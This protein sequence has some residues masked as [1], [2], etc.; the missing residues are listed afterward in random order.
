METEASR[1]G[2]TYHIAD[3]G[4][5][6]NKGEKTVTMYS[7]TGD[8]FR[9]R[10]QINSV[11]RPSTQSVGS[12]TNGNNVLFT[13]TGGWII[14]HETGRYTRFPREHGVHV[15]HSWVIESPTETHVRLPDEPFPGR[16]CQ[17]SAIPRDTWNQRSL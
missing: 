8:Q 10:C 9:A 3:E 7:E 11:T 1:Q 4:V 13:P 15:L 6:K 5:I 12:V 16:E 14:N 17:V 2:Q